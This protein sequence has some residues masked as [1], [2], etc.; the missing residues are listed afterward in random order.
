MVTVGRAIDKVLSQPPQPS[1][2]S[3]VTCYPPRQPPTL[4]HDSDTQHLPVRSHRGA[5]C[6]HR[7]SAC[8]I[9]GHYLY[10]S[11]SKPDAVH[12]YL[13]TVWLDGWHRSGALS[14]DIDI[15]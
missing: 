5:Q 15:G 2:P 3:P 7:L 1:L 9:N 10:G 13:D 6:R 14:P 8:R 4:C 11:A 12:V